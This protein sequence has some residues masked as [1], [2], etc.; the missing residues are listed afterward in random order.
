MMAAPKKILRLLRG[1]GGGAGQVVELAALVQALGGIDSSNLQAVAGALG[2]R[3]RTQKEEQARDAA[4]DALV[5][6]ARDSSADAETRLQA[7]E[8]VLDATE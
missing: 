5:G 1:I 8:A 3:E 7:A 2:Q 6:I 4:L